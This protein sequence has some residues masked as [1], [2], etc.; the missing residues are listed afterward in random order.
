MQDL[1]KLDYWYSNNLNVLNKKY[2]KKIN[3]IFST[4]KEKKNRVV[5]TNIVN[6][7]IKKIYPKLNKAHNVNMS[8]EFWKKILFHWYF[9][10][11]DL[12]Y[13]NYQKPQKLVLLLFF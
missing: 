8:H 1:K 5:I 10:F 2:S 11:T 7:Q 4:A 12:I 13:T 3:T 9:Y 6:T